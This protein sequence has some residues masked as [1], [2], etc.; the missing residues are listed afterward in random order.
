MK[1]TSNCFNSFRVYFNQ[2]HARSKCH[3]SGKF[4]HQHTTCFDDV[5]FESG[6]RSSDE[7]CDRSRGR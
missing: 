2:C 4:C 6:L 3:W 7:I 5:G 1:E